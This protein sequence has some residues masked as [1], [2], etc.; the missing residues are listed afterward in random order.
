MK[1]KA[2]KQPEVFEDLTM[3]VKLPRRNYS[4]MS[5]RQLLREGRLMYAG[6]QVAWRVELEMPIPDWQVLESLARQMKLF[7]QRAPEICE[8]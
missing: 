1:K 8:L 7:E 6:L 5:E 4:K 2:R 3:P